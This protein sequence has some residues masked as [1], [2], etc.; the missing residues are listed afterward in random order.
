M[1]DAADMVGRGA[2]PK[3]YQGKDGREMIDKIRDSMTDREFAVYCRG[4]AMKYNRNLDDDR[5]VYDN[6]KAAFYHQMALHVFNP[7]KT[8]DPRSE[9]PG[10]EPYRRQGLPQALPTRKIDVLDHGF[11]RLIEVSGGGE[12]RLPE[13]GIIEAAR[14][15]TQGSF[16]GWERDERLLA[17]LYNNRHSTPFEFADMVIEVRAPVFV[18]RQWHRHRTQ[19]YNEASGRYT[20]LPREDYL[21][22]ARDLVVRS[23]TTHTKQAARADRA[24]IVSD[25]DAERWVESLADTYAYCQRVYEQGLEIGIPKE[26]ARLAT[27]VGRYSQMRAKASLRNWLGFLTLRMDPHAQQE[28]RMFANAVGQLIAHEFP[29]TWELFQLGRNQ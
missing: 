13:A 9:R 7:E 3:R 21:P 10:F 6:E 16:R 19:S 20:E 23:L 25:A 28:T 29:R 27:T 5:A 26:V 12:T 8:P 22:D 1:S 15:S 24:P 17:Y 18:F 11:V 4:C 14:Q 2:V